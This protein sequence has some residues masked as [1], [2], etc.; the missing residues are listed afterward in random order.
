MFLIKI[1]NGKENKL[2]KSG[3]SYTSVIQNQGFD[4]I[5]SFGDFNNVEILTDVKQVCA[6]YTHCVAVTTDNKLYGIGNN[7]RGQLGLKETQNAK[8]WCFLMD[9][10][11]S[12]HTGLTNTI[13]K[14]SEGYTYATG[15]FRKSDP[16][17]GVL[18][19]FKM[20][21]QDKIA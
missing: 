10:V 13:V 5:V 12:V 21:L 3:E 20:I 6:G 15:D 7:V 2:I 19:E 16:V 4:V 8:G 14:N 1:V 18:K 9:N 11:A 17:L